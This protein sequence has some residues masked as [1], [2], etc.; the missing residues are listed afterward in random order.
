M[1]LFL[2]VLL[3]VLVNSGTASAATERVTFTLKTTA[4]VIEGKATTHEQ[5]V[6]GVMEEINNSR[7][8]QLRVPVQFKRPDTGKMIS[9][10]FEVLFLHFL[11]TVDKPEAFNVSSWINGRPPILP[12]SAT[13]FVELR[14]MEAFLGSRNDVYLKIEKSPDGRRPRIQ[15]TAEILDFEVVR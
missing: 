8:V 9:T 2:G 13:N 5:K 6:E 12:R 15:L 14:T 1:K 4:W 3:M 11:R 7:F 10:T